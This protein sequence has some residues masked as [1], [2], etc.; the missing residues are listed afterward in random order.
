MVNSKVKVKWLKVIRAFACLFFC[1][2]YIFFNKK[3]EGGDTH[4]NM[5]NDKSM[6]FRM[7]FRGGGGSRPESC[8]GKIPRSGSAFFTKIK[9]Q[10]RP[11]I[12]IFG[13]T[14]PASA[15]P[16]RMETRKP[17]PQ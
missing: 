13:H 12:R 5:I 9:F 14:V 16:L 4:I 2:I 15:P 17:A 3:R 7:F 11:A 6:A 10:P 1:D 8:A